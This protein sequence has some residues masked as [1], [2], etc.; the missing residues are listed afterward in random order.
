MHGGAFVSTGSPNVSECSGAR[1]VEAFPQYSVSLHFWLVSLLRVLSPELVSCEVFSL[2]AHRSL[3]KSLCVSLM[4]VTTGLGL[5]ACVRV[6][7]KSSRRGFLARKMGLLLRT[8]VLT[9]GPDCM[10]MN[11]LR[12]AFYCSDGG[13]A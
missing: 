5:G 4:V 3:R 11:K 10:F 13:E 9:R 2:A 7:L 12:L 6:V 1:L 8:E